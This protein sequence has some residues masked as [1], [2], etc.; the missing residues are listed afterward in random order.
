[1]TNTVTSIRTL[2]RHIEI[3]YYAMYAIEIRIDKISYYDSY[4]NLDG[5]SAG[6]DDAERKY[7]LKELHTNEDVE[8]MFDHIDAHPEDPRLF[9]TLAV[10]N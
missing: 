8:Y 2:K 9:A 1:M 3:L 6:Y 5:D 4:I 7:E 10:V